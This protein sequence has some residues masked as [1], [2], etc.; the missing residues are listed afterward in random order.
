MLGAV[1]MSGRRFGADTTFSIYSH[2]MGDNSRYEPIYRRPR[3][4]ANALRMKEE[5]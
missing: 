2:C 3:L 1:E 4:F 5:F